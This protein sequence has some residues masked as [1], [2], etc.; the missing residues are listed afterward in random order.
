M[1]Y[2]LFIAKKKKKKEKKRNPSF[3]FFFLDLFIINV[4]IDPAK[5]CMRSS[6]H[7]S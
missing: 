2:R 5:F 6:T 4:L 3:F 7:L 1:S